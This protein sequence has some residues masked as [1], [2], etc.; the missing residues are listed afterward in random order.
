M[1]TPVVDRRF[2]IYQVPSDYMDPTLRPGDLVEI[3]TTVTR[4]DRDGLFLIDFERGDPALRRVQL[5]P[6]GRA[7]ISCDKTS[8]S[9]EVI[10]R[11]KLRV[12]GHATRA[13]CEK[14]F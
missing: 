2:V 6:G 5:L 7:R 14:R 10:E 12:L 13:M 8:D 4:A 9:Q 3:D 11:T 1:I